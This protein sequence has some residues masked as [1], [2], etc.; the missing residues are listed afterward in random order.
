MSNEEMYSNE[1][2]SRL[3]SDQWSLS[4][5]NKVSIRYEKNQRR[6]RIIFSATAFAIFGIAIIAA[7]FSPSELMNPT[8][9]DLD[10][11]NL[12]FSDELAPIYETVYQE[13][14][15]SSFIEPI[16]FLVKWLA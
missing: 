11:Y 6:N 4:I 2:R 8:I 12:F 5:A 16:S 10:L 7:L 15:I 1:I 9:A 14:R 3:E 13:E